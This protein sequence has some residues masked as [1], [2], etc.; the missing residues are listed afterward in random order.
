MRVEPVGD[1]A[2]KVTWTVRYEAPK[3]ETPKWTPS[4]QKSSGN[5]SQ[6]SGVSWTGRRPESSVLKG[7]SLQKTFDEAVRKIG[8]EILAVRADVSNWRILNAFLLKQRGALRE[9]TLC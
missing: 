4:S 7:C 5:R 8:G 2:S 1:Q 9:Y 6:N 3:I